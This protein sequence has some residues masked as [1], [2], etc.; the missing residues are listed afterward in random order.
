MRVTT[1]MLLALTLSVAALSA[2][3]D[4]KA[5][6]QLI[7]ETAAEVIAAVKA[8]KDLRGGNQKKL[9]ALVEAKILPHFDFEKMTRLAVGR[10]WRTATAEQRDAL[11]TQFRTLLVRTY[12]AAFSRYENQAVDVKAPL[13]SDDSDNEVTVDTSITKPGSPAIAVNYEMERKPDGWKVFDLTI[14]GA[15]LIASYRG[16]FQEQVQQGGID[17]LIKFL[18]DK[19]R[20]NVGQSL[21]KAESR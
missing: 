6:D 2:R 19:N 18:S 9:L 21:K 4:V 16:T 7:R 13:K 14:E 12:T 11:V 10:P 8:D 3:A 5:P 20:A 17:G 1:R 15:S